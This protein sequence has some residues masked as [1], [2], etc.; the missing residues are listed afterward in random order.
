MTIMLPILI[1]KQIILDKLI[2]LNG[3]FGY[4][5]DT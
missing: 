1:A 2:L 5:L 4:Y 3:I